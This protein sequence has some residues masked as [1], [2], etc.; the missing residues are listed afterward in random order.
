MRLINTNSLQ[1]K[2]FFGDIPP[3][4]ILSHTWAADVDEVTFQE[5]RKRKKVTRAKSGYKKIQ[6]AAEQATKDGYEWLWVDTCCIDKRSSAELSEAINSMFKYYARSEICYA[7]LSDVT[8]GEDLA[9]PNSGFRTSRWFL[10][11][12]TLQELIAPWEVIFFCSSWLQL[13]KRSEMADL[14]Q[15]VTGID[16]DALIGH[17]LEEFSVAKRMSWASPRSTKR[18]EDQAYCL[19]GLFNVSMPPLYGDGPK[20]FIRLQEEII[21]WTDDHSLLAWTESCQ[22]AREWEILAP[23]PVQFLAGNGDDPHEAHCRSLLVN[24]RAIL[25]LSKIKGTAHTFRRLSIRYGPLSEEFESRR[26][27]LW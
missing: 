25:E 10:R 3:Y 16:Q 17:P 5:F 26:I 27:Y 13:G 23:S 14:I 22:Q 11:G 6:R 12:W 19:F 20:A 9:S 4:A 7:L 18:I 21:K 2:E 1:L 24:N 8:I 15:D